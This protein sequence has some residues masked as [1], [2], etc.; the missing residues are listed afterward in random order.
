MLG[1]SSPVRVT[2]TRSD[3]VYERERERERE[4]TKMGSPT[5]RRTFFGILITRAIVYGGLF[6]GHP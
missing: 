6:W 1:N 3:T 5:I 4:K 2:Q